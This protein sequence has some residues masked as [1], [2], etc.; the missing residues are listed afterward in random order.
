[1][2]Q[3]FPSPYRGYHLSTVNVKM[4][5][6]FLLLF[7]SPYRGYHL[8]TKQFLLTELYLHRFRPLIG[9]IIFQQQQKSLKLICRHCFRP[10]IGVIIFQ[11]MKPLEDGTARVVFVSVPL[12]GLSSFN[13]RGVHNRQTQKVSVPLSGLSSFN[14]NLQEHRKLY[15]DSRFRPL[16]GV[17]IFQ[18]I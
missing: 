1:M 8:S 10:L 4:S 17:I 18:L 11:H 16:I 2:S 12:S 13:G 6:N 5:K 14:L 7:P 15:S 9:V 3:K